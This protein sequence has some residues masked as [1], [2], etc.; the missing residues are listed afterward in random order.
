EKVEGRMASLS[1]PFV[2]RPVMTMLLTVTIIVFGVM[3]YQRLPVN[4]LP[5]IDFP[6]INVTVSYPGASPLTM[7]NNVAT[8]LE[9]NFLQIPGLELITSTSTQGFTT[10]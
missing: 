3:S 5:A 2:K 6:V 4:D 8:P 7:A 9:K 10:L 1:E